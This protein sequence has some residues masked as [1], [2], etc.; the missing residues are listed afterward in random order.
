MPKTFF[1]IL[2]LLKAKK[3]SLYRV[4]I[5]K[6]YY[7]PYFSLISIYFTY[8]LSLSVLILVKIFVQQLCLITNPLSK[9]GEMM[10]HGFM[11]FSMHKIKKYAS[12]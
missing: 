1:A 9:M 5:F 4:S 8:I 11:A 3:F 2:I 10:C 6:Y 7:F 12:T